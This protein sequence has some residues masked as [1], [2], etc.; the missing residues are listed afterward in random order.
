MR[1]G[2]AIPSKQDVLQA[3]VLSFDGHVLIDC[4]IGVKS[5]GAAARS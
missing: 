5:G 3:G 4:R 1:A 2:A